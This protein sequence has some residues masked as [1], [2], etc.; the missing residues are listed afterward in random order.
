MEPNVWIDPDLCVGTADCTRTAP[1]IFEL[2]ESLG[3]AVLREGA[4]DPATFDAQL[5]LVEK[6][7]RECPTSAIRIGPASSAA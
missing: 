3:I 6:A 7:A 2:D 5:A 4:L 1:G